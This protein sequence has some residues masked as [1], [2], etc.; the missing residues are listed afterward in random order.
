MRVLSTG[1]EDEG[2]KESG[3]SEGSW[4]K[5]P[6]LSSSLP[7]KADHYTSA[8]SESFSLQ[9]SKT[10]PHREILDQRTQR[11]GGKREGRREVELTAL[12]FLYKPRKE[13]GCSST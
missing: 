9:S 2:S 1:D 5:P 13:E 7:T 3:L 10:H 6:T 4:E 8:A 12:R 11:K